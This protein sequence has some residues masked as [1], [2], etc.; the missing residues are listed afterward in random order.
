MRNTDRRYA[1]VFSYPRAFF[2]F[3]FSLSLSNRNVSMLRACA[4]VWESRTIKDRVQIVATFSR[5]NV[6]N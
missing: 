4:C 2:F 1:I 5:A 6:R 3:L